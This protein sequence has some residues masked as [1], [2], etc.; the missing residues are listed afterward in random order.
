MELLFESVG[1]NHYCYLYQIHFLDLAVDRSLTEF[2]PFPQ[3]YY[4]LK[5]NDLT[6]KNLT[7]NYKTCEI[8]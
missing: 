3:K 1:K 7:F 4:F 6:F 2:S 8:V 5:E